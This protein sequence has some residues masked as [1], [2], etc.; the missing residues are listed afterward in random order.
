MDTL[1]Y[2]AIFILGVLNVILFFKIWVMT[3]DI[4]KI[5]T[6]YCQEDKTPLLI[7]KQLILCGKHQD[8]TDVLN[9]Y[10]A[11]Y[12]QD[13]YRHWYGTQNADE[14]FR[15]EIDSKIEALKPFYDAAGTAVSERLAKITFSEY[16]NFGKKMQ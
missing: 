2:F 15:K 3:N 14:S 6:K 7:V 1:I 5:M 11:D 8:A 9:Q 13:R 4:D 16:S 10:L 12:M